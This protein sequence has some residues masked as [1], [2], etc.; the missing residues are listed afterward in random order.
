MAKFCLYCS[1][2]TGNQIR[3]RKNKVQ[4]YGEGGSITHYI[5][6]SENTPLCPFHYCYCRI[7]SML[8]MNN[9]GMTFPTHYITHHGSI[10]AMWMHN[11]N[12]HFTVKCKHFSYDSYIDSALIN[13]T[14]TYPQIRYLTLGRKA[15][16]EINLN[17]PADRGLIV[18]DRILEAVLENILNNEYSCFVCGLD[19]DC[20][21]GQKIV[22]RHLKNKCEAKCSANSSAEGAPLNSASQNKQM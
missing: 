13:V 1:K 7:C 6:T 20:F 16:I 22:Y 15:F 3:L 11:K 9:G 8:F 10:D 4:S 19:Y 5:C 18:Y 14:N 12:N 17:N 21:P 2:V